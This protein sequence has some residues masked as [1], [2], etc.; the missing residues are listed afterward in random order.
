MKINKF[1]K[2]CLFTDCCVLQLPL[3]KDRHSKNNSGKGEK[4]TE[5]TADADMKADV[6]LH[7]CAS[8]YRTVSHG[9]NVSTCIHGIVEC[10]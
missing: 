2:L 7:S 3:K 10:M 5:K 4:K 9:C 8:D 1:A 6:L